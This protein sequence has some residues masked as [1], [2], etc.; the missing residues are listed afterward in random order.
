MLYD[1]DIFRAMMEVISMHALP[2]E[3]LVRPGFGDRIMAA[4]ERREAFVPPGPSRGEL[5]RMLA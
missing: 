3:V 1:S 2:A 4:A 5:L